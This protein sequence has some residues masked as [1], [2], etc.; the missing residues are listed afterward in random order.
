MAGRG[1]GLTNS[2]DGIHAR[3]SPS[4]LPAT[5][6]SIALD[7]LDYF[8]RRSTARQCGRTDSSRNKPQLTISRT[9]P[10]RASLV[11][12]MELLEP[13]T[14]A[15]RLRPSSPI[16]RASD[17]AAASCYSAPFDPQFTDR[18][19]PGGV[20]VGRCRGKSGLNAEQFPIVSRSRD[21]SGYTCRRE[22]GIAPRGRE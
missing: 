14:R 13:V 3:K 8:F 9:L 16:S 2:W 17:L 10:K 5:S 15:Q 20:G 21:P 11:S 18:W 12:S 1:S 7:S 19:F 22:A 4:G 6:S